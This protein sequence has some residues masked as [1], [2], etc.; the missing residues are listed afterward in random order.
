MA[1]YW[2]PKTMVE[3]GMLPKDQDFKN[4]KKS[5]ESLEDQNNLLITMV[6]WLVKGHG[7]SFPLP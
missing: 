2:H 1:L 5:M 6:S 7:G 3:L 4:L